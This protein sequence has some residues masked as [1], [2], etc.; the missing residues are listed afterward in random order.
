[1]AERTDKKEIVFP[2]EILKQQDDPE[3]MDMLD[4]QRR[5]FVSRRDSIKSQADILLQKKAQY[6]NEIEGLQAQIDSAT[7]QIGFLQ[8]EINAVST[9]LRQGNAQRPRLLSLQRAQADLRG[10]RGEYQSSIS[11]AEQAIAES[12]LQIV[13]LHNEFYNKVAAEY[14]ENADKV[15]DLQE[16]LKASVDIMDRI[17]I[18]APLSGIVTDLKAHTVGGVIRPGERVMDIVPTDELVVEAMISPQDIDVVKVGQDARVRLS[19][20]QTRTVSPVEATVISVSADRFDDPNN[21]N[22]SYYLA[23]VQ[24]KPHEL[25]KQGDLKLTPGMPAD[26]MMI[27]GERSL[28]GYMM[29][30]ITNSLHKAFREQ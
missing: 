1:M 24:I 17:I 29:T 21:P 6:S 3:V 10:R 25:E 18:A 15:A 30:P 8:Q 2:E 20:F 13:N 14:K 26:V 19:A 7:A 9:L 16:R 5:L 27:N 28:V 23:R 11:K 12:D 22:H 4:S